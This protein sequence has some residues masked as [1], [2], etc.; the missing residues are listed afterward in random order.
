MN[1]PPSEVGKFKVTNESAEFISVTT[2]FYTL[3]EAKAEYVR[4]AMSHPDQ[5]I[6]IWCY[7]DTDGSWTALAA[8]SGR[9][10]K[11]V[12]KERKA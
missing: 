1:V 3:E 2:T 6:V 5:H 10:Q 8:N 12:G 9:W 4:I 7:T 11:S